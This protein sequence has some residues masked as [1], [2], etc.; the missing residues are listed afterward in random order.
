MMVRRRTDQKFLEW[1]R[2]QRLG[3]KR[4][5]RAAKDPAAQA[6]LLDEL[7]WPASSLG[8][9]SL[10]AS[11][12]NDECPLSRPGPAPLP[13][14]LST[15]SRQDS[16]AG[17]AHRRSH[18][19]LAFPSEVRNIIYHFAIDYPTCRSMFDSYYRYNK[20]DTAGDFCEV[21]FHYYTPT[22]LLLCKQVTREALTV[23][24]SRPFVID[25]IPPWV[26]GQSLPLPITYFVTPPT[27]RSIRFLEIKITLGE[28]THGS[29][30]VWRRVLDDVFAV[31][32]DG[33]SVARL[34]VMFKL[35]NLEFEDMWHYWELTEYEQLVKFVSDPPRIH[36][37]HA[38]THPKSTFYYKVLGICVA[39][40]L[41]TG[42]VQFDH[43]QFKCAAKPGTVQYEHWILDGIYAFRSGFRS[44]ISSPPPFPR[45]V[46][47]ILTC[48]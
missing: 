31:W 6:L 35:C 28:G 38:P 30:Q 14:F 7:S 46:T 22:V 37:T 23:L 16:P 17:A 20:P 1:T 42:L 5:D 13:G 10:Q 29:G 27:L 12:V 3:R 18:S 33:N 11:G 47:L 34:R 8:A 4:I 40:M 24:R 44:K 21:M 45:P 19:F 39:E 43:F 41:T 26:L 9:P 2:T 15:L 36:T 32:R 48:P 25:R